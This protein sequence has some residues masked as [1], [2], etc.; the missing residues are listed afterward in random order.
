MKTRQIVKKAVALMLVAIMAFSGLGGI[1]TARAYSEASNTAG[2]VFP[3]GHPDIRTGGNWTAWGGHEG[4]WLELDFTGTRVYVEATG[5]AMGGALTVYINNAIA[6]EYLA[7]TSWYEAPS[8]V[9]FDVPEGNNT[10]R[11]VSI[12]GHYH[13]WGLNFLSF[14][15]YGSADNGNDNDNDND[16]PQV[17]I[18]VF[19]RGHPALVF[20]GL[21]WPPVP[22]AAED[23]YLELEVTGTRVYVELSG[24]GSGGHFM[25]YFDG[26]P[27]TDEPY[28]FIPSWE[29][30]RITTFGFDIPSGQSTL[31]LVSLSGWYGG[32]YWGMN[33]VRITVHR[34]AEILPPAATPVPTPV[35]ALRDPGVLEIANYADFAAGIASYGPLQFRL[36][37]A[38]DWAAYNHAT[39]I[40]GIPAG[41][42]TLVVRHAGV[43]GTYSASDASEA[44][45]PVEFAPVV[46]LSRPFTQGEFIGPDQIHR[47]GYFWFDGGSQ[48][49]M[50]TTPGSY[51]QFS[52]T[53]T[54]FYVNMSWTAIV[55]GN[56]WFNPFTYAYIEING[57][58][59]IRFYNNNNGVYTLPVYRVTGLPYGNHTVRL[60][61]NSQP[62]ETFAI[63][64][65]D[66]LVPVVPAAVELAYD[67]G[68]VTIANYPA[69]YAAYTANYGSLQFY[70]SAN[71]DMTQAALDTA[72]WAAYT[73]GNITGAVGEYVYLRFAG[74]SNWLASY[75]NSAT[76]IRPSRLENNNPAI[77][78]VIALRSLNVLYITN[79]VDYAADIAQYGSL[80]FRLNNTG[81]WIT[82]ND[83]AGISAQAAGDFFIVVRHAG[84][85][86]YLPGAISANSNT[87][88]IEAPDTRVRPFTQGEVILHSNI[89]RGGGD[90]WFDVDTWLTTAAGAYFQF[91]FIGTGFDVNMHW[92]ATATD[93]PWFNTFTYAYI[94]INGGAPFRFYNHGGD[95]PSYR[96]TGLPYGNHTVRLIR[97]NVQ[98]ETF[99]VNH[100][101]TFVPLVPAT[102]ELVYNGGTVAIDNYPADY[103][104]YTAEYGALWFYVS[105][106]GNMTQA[107]LDGV[108]WTAYTGGNITG[109]VGQYVY[110]RFAGTTNWLAS[111]A[112]PATVV[113]AERLPNNNPAATPV[114]AQRMP[115]A[116]YIANYVSYAAAIAQFGPLQFQLNGAGDWINYDHTA[117]IPIAAAGTFFIVVRHA[118]NYA[119]LPSLPSDS[120]NSVVID[121]GD[122]RIMPYSVNRILGRSCMF[123]LFPGVTGTG[124]G[125]LLSTYAQGPDPIWTWVDLWGGQGILSQQYGDG[126]VYI[127]VPFTGVG[128]HI[129]QFGSGQYPGFTDGRF[130]IYINDV[131]HSHVDKNTLP[132]YSHIY[133]DDL[134]QGDHILRIVKRGWGGLNIVYIALFEQLDVP[135]PAFE[136]RDDRVFILDP[137]VYSTYNFGV[138]NDYGPL[139][140]SLD[141]GATWIYYDSSVGFGTIDEIHMQSVMVRF[142]GTEQ[143]FP[144]NPSGARVFD[145]DLTYRTFDVTFD[146]DFVALPGVAPA[147]MRVMERY[148][149]TLPSITRSG[150]DFLGW[151]FVGGNRDGQRAGG[152]S[153]QFT[154]QP[155]D[156]DNPDDF[157]NINLIARWSPIIVVGRT[158]Y[159][160]M[161][162]GCDYTGDGSQVAPFRTIEHLNQ[163][164]FGP[165]DVISFMRG[166]VWLNLC[167]S[168]QGGL[169]YGCNLGYNHSY[170]WR[171]QG[172]GTESS[173]ILVQAWGNPSLPRPV[174]NGSGRHTTIYIASEDHIVI[175]DIHVQN[176]DV[177]DG[178]RER[179]RRGIFI[180]TWD[181]VRRTGIHLLDIH[182]S[183]I[184][185]TAW[186]DT[187]SR[188]GRACFEPACPYCSYEERYN[189][190]LPCRIFF[191]QWHLSIAVGANGAGGVHN[192]RM[193]DSYIFDL[194]GYGINF[195]LDTR[196][197]DSVFR[198]NVIRNTG[199]DSINANFSLIEQNAFY[200]NARFWTTFRPDD[201]TPDWNRHRRQWTGV[202]YGF[203][204]QVIQYNLFARARYDHDSMAVDWDMGVYGTTVVQFNFSHDNEG[205]FVMMWPGMPRPFMDAAIVRY[206]FSIN[207]GNGLN[208][209]IGDFEYAQYG[210]ATAQDV[211]QGGWEG[212][213]M[214]NNT[215]VKNNGYNIGVFSWHQLHMYNNIFYATN[216]LTTADG[217]RYRF[218]Q[219]VATF[220]GTA[221]TLSL[222]HNAFWGRHNT[223]TLADMGVNVDLDAYAIHADPTFLGP[224]PTAAA[225]PWR[226]MFTFD[227]DAVG[228]GRIVPNMTLHELAAPYMLHADSPLA[229]AGRIITSEILLAAYPNANVELFYIG[230]G[231]DFFGSYVPFDRTPTIGAHE[232][233]TFEDPICVAPDDC[234]CP[235]CAYLAWRETIRLAE[236]AHQEYLEWRAVV[237]Q[238]E[239][240]HQAYLEW[241]AAVEQAE[242]EHQA[243]LAW[244]AA[245]EQAE[246]EYREWREWLCTTGQCGGCAICD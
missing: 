33:F 96:V 1:V 124:P 99:S 76:E 203:D 232:V 84:N 73:G 12:Y 156:G 229:G 211:V 117:G 244:R 181:G 74:N 19:E 77:T 123:G 18:E 210:Y 141:G 116:L 144:S 62:W 167:N 4:A 185:G 227:T 209:A 60:I 234:E 202:L 177:T 206:N 231:R 240:D 56:Q 118:G 223:G 120:S 138:I 5:L 86:T 13:D 154:P 147:P 2:E 161:S 225:T 78:P 88:N 10:I 160:S 24:A 162:I 108:A 7:L 127:E 119:Y 166:D 192:F 190:D 149:V 246:R 137:S 42:Y 194:G 34:P 20:G 201:G 230:K 50:S 143:F 6:L 146:V 64:H 23:A 111:Y 169:R 22:L 216:L 205:G 37:D 48:T 107:A 70:V 101:D 30:D 40:T 130:D 105:A 150:H 109:A 128:F 243:Y 82:Y 69:G 184:Q 114:L 100:F 121:A 38:G 174:I 14:T 170:F 35:L 182:V 71:G 9:G 93:N 89:H 3:F 171:I 237:E 158:F 8:R 53:G 65:F 139:Q 135:A 83:V 75:A 43:A 95:W 47:G 98:W 176:N 46:T 27:V 17:E 131:F 179:N 238:A 49:Y 132:V 157:G 183:Q 112:N 51:F 142:A 233:Q 145:R 188:I 66:T 213:F 36:N 104:A 57:G 29:G 226:T 106:N 31:R 208:R 148:Y 187:V 115:G 214:Y 80:E 129:M 159:M 92:S 153:Q 45:N 21:W 25:A 110:L 126:S 81:D 197:L 63:S 193:E 207:D 204:N 11:V 235:D 85:A 164:T 168:L 68:T 196:T 224:I 199:M 140:F 87:V 241:R 102:P 189:P 55:L 91:S 245:I 61:R 178:I 239:R 236:I 41:T 52:F 220:W 79:L 103:A 151:Y 113:P 195:S 26:V 172:S 136:A 242:R 228:D 134:P 58:A 217:N 15:V 221:D 133:V 155:G 198:N 32:W 16:D 67:N 180:S 186:H 97:N 222:S 173:P 59:P 152:A 175:R 165:G 122:L 90:F 125:H 200:D 44:S 212:L 54:G 215:F 94:E 28:I 39:G 163:F 218:N 191:G 72:A 219:D